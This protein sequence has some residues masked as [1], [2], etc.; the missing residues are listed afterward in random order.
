VLGIHLTGEAVT[1]DLD[2]V[3]TESHPE[4]GPPRPAEQH[5]YR[6]GR[7]A[8]PDPRVVAVLDA[9]PNRPSID[10]TGERDFGNIDGLELDGGRYRV[11]G[12][13]GVVEIESG[14]AAITL[15]PVDVPAR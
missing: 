4:Y 5:C 15:E 8:F 1:F 11:T 12:D 10:A 7:L 6:R 2:V 3:L 14:P 13:W 9:R